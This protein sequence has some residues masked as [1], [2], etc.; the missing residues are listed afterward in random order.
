MVGDAVA[1]V[2]DAAGFDVQR[3]YYVND[4]GNQVK[5]LG[6]SILLRLRELQGE[7]ID[8]PED[9]YQAAYIVDLAT[10]LLS[11]LGPLTGIDEDEA[12]RPVPALGSRKS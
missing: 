1:A 4:A 11:E 7:S 12:L 10:R 8:F 2:L 6:R 3:E 5:T 9:G